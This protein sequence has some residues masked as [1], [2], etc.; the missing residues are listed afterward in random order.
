MRVQ[1]AQIPFD[2]IFFSSSSSAFSFSFLCDATR[3]AQVDQSTTL[4]WVTRRRRSR[5][6][7]W[8]MAMNGHCRTLILRLFT[9]RRTCVFI[10]LE[11]INWLRWGSLHFRNR[12]HNFVSNN[13]INT[14]NEQLF[15]SWNFTTKI[16]KYS[17]CWKVFNWF[18]VEES[19][20]HW[21]KL[22][23]LNRKPIEEQSNVASVT[24][25]NYVSIILDFEW[26]YYANATNACLPNDPTDNSEVR[27]S[28]K[29]AWSIWKIQNCFDA[30]KF[31]SIELSVLFS[32]LSIILFE[33]L[34]SV[35][36]PLRCGITLKKP[37]SAHKS[38]QADRYK[39]EWSGRTF[40]LK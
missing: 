25:A 12:E 4:T 1:S 13:V 14:E 27:V 19:E 31:T 28:V 38:I 22:R 34:N 2:P 7:L 6:L 16:K 26:I 29:C 24:T 37:P 9:W 21:M 18:D 36:I 23:H 15:W 33:V 39:G 10:W 8:F 3:L 17:F 32:M 20:P 5:L 30:R 11:V 40:I 35:L